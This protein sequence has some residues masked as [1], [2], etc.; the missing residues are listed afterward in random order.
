MTLTTSLSFLE[1]CFEFQMPVRSMTLTTSIS[2]RHDNMS[3]QM[4]VRSMTLTTVGTYYVT[5]P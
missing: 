4:P 1:G 2:S 3:F 5:C